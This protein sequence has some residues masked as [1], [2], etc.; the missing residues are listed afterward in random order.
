MCLESLAET[1]NLDELEQ[2]GL[3]RLSLNTG[4]I[5]RLSKKVNTSSEACQEQCEMILLGDKT[6][7][8][9]TLQ[10]R[11]IQCSCF[12][13]YHQVCLLQQITGKYAL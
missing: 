12:C 11:R 1:C 7:K 8:E 10:R 13:F 9:K 3:S 5:D 2:T 6:P 4:T